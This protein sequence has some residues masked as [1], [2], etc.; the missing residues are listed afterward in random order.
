MAQSISET[1]VTELWKSL[2]TVSILRRSGTLSSLWVSKNWLGLSGSHPQTS[3]SALNTF[4]D[5]LVKYFLEDTVRNS[6]LI[7]IQISFLL[8]LS[9]PI[10]V[11]ERLSVANQSQHINSIGLCRK[12]WS[13]CN[14]DAHKPGVSVVPLSSTAKR[15]KDT[16]GSRKMFRLFQ[17]L[18]TSFIR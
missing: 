11:S 3:L 15:G 7:F 5:S 1:G 13:V 14:R 9:L 12:P 18:S 2:F 10:H 17:K 6:V 8:T 16:F 4:L